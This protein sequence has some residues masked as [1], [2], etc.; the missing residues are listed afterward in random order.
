[1]I[2]APT[3]SSVSAAGVD[4]ATLLPMRLAPGGEL[5]RPLVQLHA[6]LTERVLLARIG[7]GDEAVKRDRGLKPEPG[8]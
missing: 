4:L 5:E 8:H 7:T 2:V 3:L 1:M 6:A